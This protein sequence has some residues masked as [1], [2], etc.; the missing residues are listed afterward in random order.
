MTLAGAR[1]SLA[2]I[3][4]AVAGVGVQGSLGV[5]SGTER[6]VIDAK[7]AISELGGDQPIARAA[8]PR[9]ENELDAT[10][11]PMSAERRWKE[12]RR[13]Q[14]RAPSKG[15]REEPFDLTVLRKADATVALSIGR[16]AYKDV[17]LGPGSLNLDLKD[18]FARLALDALELYGG[19]AQGLL[20]LDASGDAPVLGANIKLAGVALLALAGDAL[21]FGW[22]DG[23]GDIALELAGQG[24][25]ERE[26][27]D[28][29][30]GRLKLRV[31]DGAMIG[32][33][34]GK[35]VGNLQQGRFT[36]LSPSPDDRTPF[37]ELAASFD[38]VNGTAASRDMRL[39]SS[40]LNLDGQGTFALGERQMDCEL[41]AKISG[42]KR[43][44]GTGISVGSLELP[45]TIRGP[46]ERP[47]YGI[48]GQDQL[49]ETVRDVGKR[50]KSPDVQDTIKGLLGSDKEERAK[51]RAKARELLENFLKKE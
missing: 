32:A 15:W 20:T 44:E 41:R 49:M 35:I 25:S 4:A 31:A 21:N 10:G 33:D 17:K 27:V 19:R 30:N 47:S 1:L 9:A 7:L 38:I 22:L 46:W 23:R 26:I 29:L 11:L 28:A 48:K 45:V 24:R 18:G 2:E 6:P 3:D 50:L 43:G 40:H 16:V 8:P 5:E 12:G 36:G 42:G 13:N 51:S 39:A 34:V 37:S 14:A